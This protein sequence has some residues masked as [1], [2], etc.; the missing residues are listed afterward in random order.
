L[1][2]LR[3][4]ADFVQEQRAAMRLLELAEMT[5]RRAGELPL[6]VAE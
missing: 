5:R 3:H 6:F 2:G 1:H 4:V